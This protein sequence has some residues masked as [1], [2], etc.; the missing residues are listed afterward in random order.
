[1][2]EPDTRALLLDSLRPPDGWELGHAI[3]T[4]FTLDL[5]ALLIAPLAFAMFDWAL[6][7]DGRP[8]VIATLEALRRNADRTTVFHQGGM[9]RP[10][11]RW[12][13]LYVHLEQSVVPVHAPREGG[14][15]HPKVWLLQF[16]KDG[17]APRYRLLTLSRNLTFD[18][19][20]DT[21]VL[22]DGDRRRRGA[23]SGVLADFVGDLVSSADVLSDERRSLLTAIADDVRGVVFSPPDE[24]REVRFHGLGYRATGPLFPA[25]ADRA[26][27]ISPFL[28]GETVR[29]LASVP[30][31]TLISRPESLD[32]VGEDGL[33]GW[34]RTLVLADDV[35]EPDEAAEPD[36]PAPEDAVGGLRGLHAKVFAFDVAG[37]THLFTG[38]AN[39]TDAG[40]RRNVEFVVELVGDASAFPVTTL[41]DA[42]DGVTS[43]GDL[44]IEY[45][46]A[47][48][49]V[50]D[51]S[52]AMS[53]LLEKAQRAIGACEFV[54]VVSEH[55]DGFTVSLQAPEPPPLPD[56][57]RA[58][59]CWCVTVGQGHQIAPRVD[60]DGQWRVDF[61]HVTYEGLS[62]FFAFEVEAELD[63]ARDRVRFVVNAQLDGAPADRAESV[64][65]RLLRSR[66]DLLRYL[67]FLLTDATTSL[68]DL[69]ENVQRV[70]AGNGDSRDPFDATDLMERLL[71]TLVR[72]PSRLD[73]VGK[74]LRDLKIAGRDSDVVPQALEDL[75]EVLD[76]VRHEIEGTA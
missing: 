2:L 76:V 38:S 66:D 14:I 41:L 20:W 34:D 26:V 40:L 70:G 1:M 61:G 29:S 75:W 35:F 24:V 37:T 44:C 55:G 25:K 30:H 52:R 58:V 10:P 43:F 56:G 67:L 59:H 73:H 57:I 21:V 15:F 19:S 4:T 12:Q 36:A 7:D 31:A 9:I 74:V 47:P 32:A 46:P 8:D 63:G 23:P 51:S 64:I 28:G 11:A 42:G 53:M 60:Q 54:A 13:P 27:V 33:I 71:R 49:A 50:A 22:L 65:A 72:D 18:T 16:T 68:G 48:A 39:A 3:G 69:V 45:T 62:S 17:Q 5:Q 6:Q